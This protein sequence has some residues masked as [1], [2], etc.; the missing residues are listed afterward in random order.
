PPLQAVHRLSGSLLLELADDQASCGRRCTNDHECTGV[1]PTCTVGVVS[2]TAAPANGVCTVRKAGKG[3]RCSLRSIIESCDTGASKNMVC[4]DLALQDGD[5]MS[6]ADKFGVCV[7]LCDMVD[8]H[9]RALPDAKHTPT[10]ELGFFNDP[11][12]G[13]CD[14]GCSAFP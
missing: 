1:A 9:C 13:I 10:C 5:N 2:S 8:M 12:L 11:E 4:T 14:D 6:D 7:E 3:A